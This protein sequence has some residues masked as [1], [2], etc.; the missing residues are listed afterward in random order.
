MGPPLLDT[1]NMYYS[2]NKSESRQSDS[3]KTYDST[4]GKI[5]NCYYPQKSP[6]EIALNNQKPNNIEQYKNLARGQCPLTNFPE[7]TY[8]ELHENLEKEYEIFQKLFINH[9]TGTLEPANLVPTINGN[10]ISCSAAGE[11][12][13]PSVLEYKLDKN[14]LK[15]IRFCVTQ[16][17]KNMLQFSNIG[18]YQISNYTNNS[19][20]TSCKSNSCQTKYPAF[21]GQNLE[22]EPVIK[23][24]PAKHN[25]NTNLIIVG[26]VGGVLLIALV[27][28]VLVEYHKKKNIKK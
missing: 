1:Y 6:T 24:A 5:L 13:H 20:N 21:V 14:Y 25:I 26:V 18:D 17:Q 9:L 4:T 15:H 12:Y 8:P 19:N 28:F 23:S 2:F 16:N 3:Y 11:S 27:I 7:K 10:N 22:P